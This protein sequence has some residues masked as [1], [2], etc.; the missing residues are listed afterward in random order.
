MA[1]ILSSL[2]SQLPA[3]APELVRL[4]LRSALA[5]PAAQ[6]LEAIPRLTAILA[7]RGRSLAPAMV[8]DRGADSPD[9]SWFNITRRNAAWRGLDPRMLDELYSVAAENIW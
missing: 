1:R 8:V 4:G 5:H 6:G 7:L 9:K 2:A 3:I